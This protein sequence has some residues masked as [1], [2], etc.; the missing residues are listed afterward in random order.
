MALI[1]IRNQ[2][3]QYVFELPAVVGTEVY[4]GT[5][6]TCPINLAGV[7]GVSPVHARIV[8][9]PEG[10]VIE[11]LQSQYG[12][13]VGERSVVQPEYM[14]PGVEYVLGQAVLVLDLSAPQAVS[15]EPVPQ[16]QPRQEA[17]KPK[18]RAAM[19][20]R[21]VGG[22]AAV[23]GSVLMTATAASHKRS[24]G[25]SAL[26]AV[27]VLVLLAIA[28]YT[29]LALHH[30]ERTGNFLPGIVADSEPEEE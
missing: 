30:W 4:V 13:R 3:Q 2:D 28:F 11:D 26:T 10:Y 18:L 20:K 21:T 5:E 6:A 23:K 14:M 27:C 22:A 8:C 25:G 15:P 16:Q 29:G 9:Q 17:G 19:P 7:G 24:G 12:T 1:Y